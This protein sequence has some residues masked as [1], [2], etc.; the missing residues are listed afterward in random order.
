MGKKMSDQTVSSAPGKAAPA[1]CP[2]CK[3]SGWWYPEGQDRG[4]AKC[5]HE[6][7]K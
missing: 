3:G 5:R 4:V 2:D 1:E 6:K 7:L